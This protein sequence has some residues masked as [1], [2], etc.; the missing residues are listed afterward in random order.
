[1]AKNSDLKKSYGI[2]IDEYDDIY[3]KQNGK[4]SI[5]GKEEKAVIRGIPLTLAVDHS[6]KTG[7]VRGLLCHKCNRAIGGLQDSVVLLR[8][9]ADYLEYWS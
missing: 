9:A 1:M 8:K 7:K 4:C 6:H 5:C 2:T 3:D